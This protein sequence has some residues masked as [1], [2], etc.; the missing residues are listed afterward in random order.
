MSF[1]KLVGWKR[2]ASLGAIVIFFMLF[3]LY[4]P[5]ENPLNLKMW[6]SDTLARFEILKLTPL[7]SNSDQVK[8]LLSLRLG[9]VSNNIYETSDRHDMLLR[10]RPFDSLG[11]SFIFLN[12]VDYHSLFGEEKMCVIWSFDSNFHLIAVDCQTREAGL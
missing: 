8:H 2:Y 6:F 11:T 9:S 10:S 1:Q 3:I 12:I 5:Q 7:G 4:W